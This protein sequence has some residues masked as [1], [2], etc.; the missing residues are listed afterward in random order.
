MISRISGL[1]QQVTEHHALVENGGIF[2]EILVPSALA[3]R[4]KDS[5]G[6]GQSIT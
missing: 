3:D 4:L 6:V 5:G 1:L 2:Y